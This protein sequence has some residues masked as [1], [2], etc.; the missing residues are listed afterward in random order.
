M[1]ILALAGWFP[2]GGVRYHFT[3]DDGRPFELR[4]RQPS[5]KVQFELLPPPQTLRLLLR[6]NLATEEAPKGRYATGYP[7]PEYMVNAGMIAG[8]ATLI[9]TIVADFLTHP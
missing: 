2:R 6:T 9:G 3:D 8:G 4:L 7:V 5:A 1:L